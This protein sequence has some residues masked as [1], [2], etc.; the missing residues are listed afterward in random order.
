M[1]T[2]TTGTGLLQHCA[3]TLFH[4]PPEDGDC[5]V[6]FLCAADDKPPQTQNEF[7]LRGHA[8]LASVFD[9]IIRNVEGRKP[10]MTC[11]K[12]L[13]FWLLMGTR[14]SA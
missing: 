11:S 1:L 10:D 2:P 7:D 9:V 8:V 3:K 6:L 14:R 12:K 5:V 4:R 13:G